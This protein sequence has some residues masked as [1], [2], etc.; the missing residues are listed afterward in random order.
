MMQEGV[1]LLCSWMRWADY[2]GVPWKVCPM[3][4]P[5]KAWLLERPANIRWL[6]QYMRECRVEL[7]YRFS[8]AIT[9]YGQVQVFDTIEPMLRDFDSVRSDPSFPNYTRDQVRGL[10]LRHL[11]CPH[12]AYQRY[13]V[14]KWESDT[15][16]PKWTGR[17]EPRW[18]QKILFDR[19]GSL[20]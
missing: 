9:S 16:T 18:R 11:E 3:P 6:L 4:N 20:T 15:H 12:D 17:D 5:I 7:I 14:V 1:Q 8:D 19:T 2:E 10:D 13:L